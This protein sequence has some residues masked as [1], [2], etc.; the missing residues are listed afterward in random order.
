MTNLI[1][2]SA[3][4]VQLAYMVHKKRT[5]MLERLTARA[6]GQPILLRDATIEADKKLLALRQRYSEGDLRHTEHEMLAV[7]IIGRWCHEK[8]EELGHTTN[9]WVF[10]RARMDGRKNPPPRG[11]PFRLKRVNLGGGRAHVFRL[12]AI[13]GKAMQS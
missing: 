9:P 1:P 7:E 8:W 12:N 11:N 5:E 13:T 2:S 4:L 3:D 6:N 10:V